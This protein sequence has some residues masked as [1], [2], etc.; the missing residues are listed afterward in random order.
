MGSEVYGHNFMVHFLALIS[1]FSDLDSVYHLINPVSSSNIPSQ[2]TGE[3]DQSEKRKVQM[4]FTLRIL[5][6]AIYRD[7]LSFKN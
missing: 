3:H 7:F 5:D 6:L 4:H 1:M 2:S